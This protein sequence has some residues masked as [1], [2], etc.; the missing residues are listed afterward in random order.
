MWI[1]TAFKHGHCSKRGSAQGTAGFL[2]AIYFGAA[3]S[4]WCFSE[5]P[6]LQHMSPVYIH[7]YTYIGIHCPQC[8][9]SQQSLSGNCPCP[10]LTLETTA[11]NLHPSPQRATAQQLSHSWGGFPKG[12]W[13]R[14]GAAAGPHGGRGR[15]PHHL[16]A[17]LEGLSLCRSS[18]CCHHPRISP[19]QACGKRKTKQKHVKTRWRHS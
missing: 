6:S 19:F 7:I 2:T 18:W 15:C 13:G 12:T 8:I 9:T 4:S 10:A 16:P 14:E 17:T 3:R 11:T 5:S 1:T